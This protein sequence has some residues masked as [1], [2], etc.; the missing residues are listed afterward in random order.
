MPQSLPRDRHGPEA[1]AE[2]EGWQLLGAEAVPRAFADPA[3][4]RLWLEAWLS[5]QCAL[6]GEVAAAT[7]TLDARAVGGAATVR[8]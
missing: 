2:S 6:I 8:R 3:Q 5:L 1:F 4:L 7:V